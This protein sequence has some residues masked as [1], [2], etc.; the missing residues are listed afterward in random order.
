MPTHC[1]IM[2]LRFIVMQIISV[3]IL[4]TSWV[5]HI[6][7]REVYICVLKEVTLDDCTCNCFVVCTVCGMMKGREEVKAS[8]GT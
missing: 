5:D 8:A 4:R 6:M 3:F 2:C 1:T 7:W